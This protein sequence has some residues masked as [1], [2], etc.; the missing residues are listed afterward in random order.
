MEP[1]R[2]NK[3]PRAEDSPQLGGNNSNK[4]FPKLEP[5]RHEETRTEKEEPPRHEE[6]QPRKGEP[7]AKSIDT[8]KPTTTPTTT[9]TT[10]ITTTNGTGPSPSYPTTSVFRKRLLDIDDP[11]KT[12]PK[13]FF[14]RVDLSSDDDVFFFKREAQWKR[15]SWRQCGSLVMSLLFGFLLPFLTLYLTILSGAKGSQSS[16]P[17]G[18]T[19]GGESLHFRQNALRMVRLLSCCLDCGCCSNIYWFIV[20]QVST[21]MSLFCT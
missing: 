12:I 10:T 17:S 15:K 3:S 20:K 9:T 13:Y 16:R 18:C 1:L 19:G 21:P 8:P 6:T 4:S 14:E 7:T 2:D 11:L 5:P